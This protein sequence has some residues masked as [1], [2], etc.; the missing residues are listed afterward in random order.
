[1]YAGHTTWRSYGIIDKM[2]KIYNF[3]L[4]NVSSR[5]VSFSSSPGFL[6]SKDDFY[7]LQNSNMV[8]METTLSIFNKT[9]YTILTPESVL[10]WVRSII[11]NQL[12]NS[13]REWTAIFSKYNSGTY[14]NQWMIVDYKRFVPGQINS[15]L[16]WILEQIPGYIRSMDASATLK[17][18]GFWSSYNIP[19]FNELYNLSGYP[20]AKQK[21]GD[22]YDYLK[23]PRARIFKRE[24]EKV[25][26]LNDFG[27]TL[28]FNQWQTDPFSFGLASNAIAS[29]YDLRK[30]KPVPFGGIDSKITN[31]KLVK[32]LIA[33]GI[34]GPT[35]Q[36]QV[37]FNW[38]S[39]DWGNVSHAGQ[40]D[41]WN[42]DWTIMQDF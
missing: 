14:N 11:A 22:D 20:E 10:C 8:T 1:L 25:Q 17:E 37:P 2:Y 31:F 7:I 16:L 15:D 9:L 39:T 28:Q 35:H 23:C 42:F 34:A 26:H 24:Q 18:Q 12:S 6:S 13:G 4:R 19:F 30:N 5:Q 40:P 38:S 33:I 41:I 36:D 27:R 29:R 3:G 32:D 21:F